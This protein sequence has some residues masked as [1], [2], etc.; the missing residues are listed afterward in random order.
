M[1]DLYDT[2][3]KPGFLA[4]AL[5]LQKC[6]PTDYEAFACQNL[7]QRLYNAYQFWA[8]HLYDYRVHRPQ[9]ARL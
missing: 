9:M 2:I 3:S 1:A 4:A 8:E 5:R 7:R 6:S